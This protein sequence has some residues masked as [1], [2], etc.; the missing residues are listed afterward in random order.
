MPGVAREAVD[1][2]LL[3]HDHRA[4]EG[5]R[6]AEQVFHDRAAAG[7]GEI[8]EKFQRAVFEKLAAVEFHAVG[9][10]DFHARVVAEPVLQRLRQAG[11][12]LDEDQLPDLSDQM[13][14]Q[15]SGARADFHHRVVRRDFE[16]GDDPARHVRVDEE[17]LPELL[18]RHHSRVK[19]RFPYFPTRHGRRS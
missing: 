1:D 10:M 18:A 6:A 14:A 2:F 7:V 11:V 5:V 9:M 17:I 3:Q 8:A 4:L 16:L 15:R 19:Q 12:E 13:L